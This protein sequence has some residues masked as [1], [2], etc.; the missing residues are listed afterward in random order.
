M[1]KELFK[2]G[3]IAAS[4]MV[5][6]VTATS[7][8]ADGQSM[9]KNQAEKQQLIEHVHKIF[10]AFLNRDRDRIRELHTR[11][12]V[13]FLGPSTKIER[14][15]GDYMI[16]ADLSLDNFRG[17]GYE[18]H[19]TEVQIYSDIALVFYI[20]SYYY[21]TDEGNTSV[22]PLRSVDVFKRENDH[23]NQAASHISV[24]PDGGKWGERIESHGIVR[25]K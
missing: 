5:A 9:N 18:I 13:G 24:I 20:A 15:I 3:V 12:W 1:S 11:D 25:V 14:G 4:M 22:I 10:R 17:T 7:I 6:I 23:W 19:D 21:E 16:N 8:M 2:T